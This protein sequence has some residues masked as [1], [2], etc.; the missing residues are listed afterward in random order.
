MGNL[1]SKARLVLEAGIHL[2]KTYDLLADRIATPPGLPVPNP[3]RPF[4]T[5][6]PSPISSDGDP[7]PDYADVVIIGSGITGASVAYTLLGLDSSLKVVMLEA[8]DVCSGATARNGGHINAPLYHD[9]SELKERYGE[10]AAEIMIRFR[11]EHLREF[12]RVALAED[13]LKVSQVRETEHLDVYANTEG[14]AQAKE[15]LAKWKN[16]MPVEASGF[17]SYDGSEAKTKFCLGEQAVG[18][19][20]NP[21][22]AIHPYRFVTSLLAKLLDRYPSQFHIATRTP[23]TAI[24]ASTASAPHYT[25]TTPHGSI[26]TPHVVHAT[27]GWVSHL[28]APL[29]AKVIPARGVMTVQR[30]GSSLSASTHDGGRSYVFYRGTT[31]YDYLT[32]LPTDEHEL[33]FGGAWAVAVSDGLPELGFADDS[34][35]NFAAAAHLA[36]A[37]PLYFGPEHWG[38]EARISE[39]VEST[40]W[41][42]GRTKAQWSGVLAISVDGLPWV[43]RVPPKVSGRAQPAPKVATKEGAALAPPGEWIAAGYTGEGM[44][45]AW[46]S[47]KALAYMVLGREGEIEAWFPDILRVTEKR[48]KAA[49]VDDMISRFM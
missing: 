46:M 36:G 24:H 25:L 29:R 42:I 39:S 48:W 49:S 23:C 43:G 20:R 8:R 30:P 47:G 9:Y 45:H 27:N 14:F 15:N 41:G 33:M 12:R 26:T 10:R 4:W 32:Q 17:E 3:T 2:S 44:V 37:L 34:E 28:L 35:Y 13:I 19:I 38:E 18:C 16:D 21:G 31:G 22:G 5:D 11:L 6:P 40:Q 1:F 7:L